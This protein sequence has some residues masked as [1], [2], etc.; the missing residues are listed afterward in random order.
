[1]ERKRRLKRL[2]YLGSAFGALITIAIT[3]LMDV[4]YADV[5]GGTWRQAIQKDLNSL[6]SISVSENSF[7]VLLVFLIILILLGSFG[8]LMGM[9]FTFFVYSFLEFLVKE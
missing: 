8:A 5:L 9:I 7:I 1:M 4:F 3:L 2:L 6:F